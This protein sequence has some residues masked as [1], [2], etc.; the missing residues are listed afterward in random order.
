VVT[1]ALSATAA[2]AGAPDGVPEEPAAFAE[3]IAAGDARYARRG[4]GADER[5]A[6][7]LEIDGAIAEYRRALALD[8]S[9]L[10]ARVR[11][12]RAYFFRGG[13]CGEMPRDEKVRLFDEA[14]RLAEEVVSRLDAELGRKK[15]K[16]TRDAASRVTPAA[17]AYLWSAVSWGQWAV[18]HRVSAAWSGAPG[19]IRDLAEAVIALDPGAEQAGAYIILGRLHSEA[20]KIPLVTG[21]VS[22]EKAVA[23]VRAGSALAPENRALAYFTA[24]VLL[25]HAPGAKKEAGEILDRV[26]STPPRPDFPAEDLHYARMARERLAG[27]R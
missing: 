23:A 14:K 8:P 5:G 6:P 19:R 27:L 17:E 25:R 11:L 15:G 1:S 3:A 24:D 22:R 16:V 26:A 13:F 12:M 20:P 2:G 21:F 9:S 18:F 10:E 4:E 7:P